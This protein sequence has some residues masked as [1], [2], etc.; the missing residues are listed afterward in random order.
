MASSDRLHSTALIQKMELSPRSMSCSLRAPAE[1]LIAFVVFPTRI[2]KSLSTMIPTDSLI[3]RL[4]LFC[5]K[6]YAD[7]NWEP[8]VPRKIR[9]FL[10]SMI[11]QP[12]RVSTSSHPT[13]EG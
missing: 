3:C 11:P 10:S 1:A 8:V 13:P 5:R 6:A 12:K 7:Q 9:R 4:S 2:E